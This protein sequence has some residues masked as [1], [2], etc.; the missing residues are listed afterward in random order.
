MDRILSAPEPT[1]RAVLV[2]L[3]DDDHIRAR[4]HAHLDQLGQH[5]A[6]A[7]PPG[8]EPSGP[9][10]PGTAL[11]KRSAPAPPPQICIRCRAAFAPDSNHPGACLHHHGSLVLDPEAD[12]VWADWDEPTFGPHDTDENRDEWPEGFT[13]T[14]CGGDGAGPGCARGPHLAV[15]GEHKRLRLAAATGQDPD[16]VRE[17]GGRVLRANEFVNE[18]LWDGSEDDLDDEAVEGDDVA[19]EDTERDSGGGDSDG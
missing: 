10:P 1:I 3:C 16:V 2:A 8:P 7:E 5:R 9:P 13:W 14:C 11:G 19:S 15:R 17:V 4:C 18:N 6:S 12:D